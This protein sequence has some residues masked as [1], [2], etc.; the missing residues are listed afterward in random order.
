[1][2]RY[3]VETEINKPIDQVIRVFADRSLLPKWQPGILGSEQIESY[4]YPK[5]KLMMTFG[6]RKMPMIETILRNELPG[7]F[8][9]TYE[10]KGIFNRVQNSFEAMGPGTTRWKCTSEFRFSG[11]M[12]IIAFFMKGDFKKQSEVIMRNFKK[13]AETYKETG[14]R[15]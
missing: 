2:V 14:S 1:M 12:R 9:G 13:F 7:H 3:Q 10:M 11:L 5:Y 8:D 15:R 4:P 6:K